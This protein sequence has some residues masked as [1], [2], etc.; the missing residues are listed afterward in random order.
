M[1]KYIENENNK[2]QQREKEFSTR[3]QK[4]QDKMNAMEDTV[5]RNEKEKS[6]KEEK[7]LLMLQQEREQRE[8][9]AEIERKKHAYEQSIQ[10]N[11]IL[12]KQMD[13]K[14]RKKQEEIQRD[15]DQQNALLHKN[16]MLR[17]NED[18]KKQQ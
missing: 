18:K 4:I 12:S 7:R 16:D 6:L 13:E 2:L 5:M 15:I 11:E 17:E 10:V 14:N 1:Q 9:K 3:L 8:I